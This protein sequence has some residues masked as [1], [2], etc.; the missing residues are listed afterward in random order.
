MKYF[1]KKFDTLYCGK[2]VMDVL[3]ALEHGRKYSFHSIWEKAVFEVNRNFE[4]ETSEK[5]KKVDETEA[6]SETRRLINIR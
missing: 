1:L 3:N 6:K 2:K 4:N 5:R